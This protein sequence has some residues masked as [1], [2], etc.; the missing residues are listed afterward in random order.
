MKT[1]WMDGTICSFLCSSL[2]IGLFDILIFT[3][4]SN[5]C[6]YWTA[7]AGIVCDVHRAWVTPSHLNVTCLM[8]RVLY[9]CLPVTPP[10]NLSVTTTN[11]KCYFY[12]FCW[13]QR[14]KTRRYYF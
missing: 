8:K 10:T 6:G 7:I 3:G 4:K 11:A 5:M 2:S 9:R 14:I 12:L 1:V 13:I